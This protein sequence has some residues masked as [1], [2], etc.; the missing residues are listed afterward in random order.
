MKKY[1]LA[2]NGNQ[3]S[4]R[5]LEV[6]SNSVKAEVNGEEHV[7]AIEDIENINMF[8]TEPPVKK[9]APAATT[10]TISG[11]PNKMKSGG[12]Y[13]PFGTGNLIAPI[14]GQI[15]SIEV[16]PGN[17]VKKG[18]RLL[19]LEAMKMENVLTATRDTVIKEILVETGEAVTQDQTMIVF[20]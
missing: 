19:I 9:P 20:E 2:I 13:C 10:A 17:T 11:Q 18:D 6:S 3:Y 1:S 8:P 12:E 15:V 4:V 14:P 7:V 5:I 16:Q